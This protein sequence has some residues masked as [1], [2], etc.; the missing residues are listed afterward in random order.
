MINSLV[1]Q[2]F[3]EFRRLL[4]TAADIYNKGNYERYGFLKEQKY[5]GVTHTEQS[6][7]IYQKLKQKAKQGYRLIADM[8]EGN[9]NEKGEP[10]EKGTSVALCCGFSY[11]PGKTYV[12]LLRHPTTHGTERGRSTNEGN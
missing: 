12:F 8:E 5:I 2:R 4:K 7:K 3:K 10:D 11:R 9:V 6:N 1:M